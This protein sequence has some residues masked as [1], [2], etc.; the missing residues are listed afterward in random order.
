MRDIGCIFTLI[1]IVLAVAVVKPRFRLSALML[2]SGF[3]VLHALVHVYD[4]L[5]GL[6]PPDQWRYD[7]VP[8]Y[9]T[10]VLLVVLTWAFARSDGGGQG[11]GG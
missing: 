2:A 9:G 8:V 6:L 1:G 11:A 7:L 3:Y 5:R 4:S 10:A